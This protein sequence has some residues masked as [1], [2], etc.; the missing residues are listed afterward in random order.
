MAISSGRCASSSIDGSIS[1]SVAPGPN[2]VEE[3]GQ[4]RVQ[5][6][7]RAGQRARA[8]HAAYLF[9]RAGSTSM[10]TPSKP[11]VVLLSGGLDSTTTLAIAQQE[12]YTAYA[13][14][15][16]YGQRHAHELEAASRIAERYEVARHIICAIDLRQFGGSA[17]TEDI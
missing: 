15:F 16:Q 14:S 8:R 10:T 2:Y 3:R 7:C 5:S 9:S 1:V 11:A 12:G 17:L 13:L 6:A 4:S